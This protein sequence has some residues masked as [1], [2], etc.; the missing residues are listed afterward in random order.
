MQLDKQTAKEMVQTV[1]WWENQI[2]RVWNATFGRLLGRQP[3][4]GIEEPTVVL[5]E[6]ISKDK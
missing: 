2:A 3:L 4:H 5:V 6:D 1:L